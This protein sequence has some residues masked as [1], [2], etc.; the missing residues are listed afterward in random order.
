M[1]VF[2][3]T[4][5]ENGRILYT[6]MKEFKHAD[7]WY[8]LEE[9]GLAGETPWTLEEVWSCARR[10]NKPF[11]PDQMM[12]DH[13]QLM[14]ECFDTYEY[15]IDGKPSFRRRPHH[16]IYWLAP[17]NLTELKLKFTIKGISQ[18]GSPF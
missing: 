8:S 3:L 4:H 2:N 7:G 6:P 15:V 12:D 5:D 14:H 13:Q 17:T 10:D 1:S 18:F 11:P 16:Y 9:D